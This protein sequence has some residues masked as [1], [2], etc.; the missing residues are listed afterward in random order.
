V[1]NSNFLIQIQQNITLKEAEAGEPEDEDTD[2]S[3][4]SENLDD[5]VE[6]RK[7]DLEQL[8]GIEDA[9]IQSI[10]FHGEH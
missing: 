3:K 2:D 4:D 8:M 5:S 9:I 7:F 10:A 1:S 6:F